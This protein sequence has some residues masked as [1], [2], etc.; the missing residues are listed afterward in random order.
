MPVR[1]FLNQVIWSGNS[2]KY[3][4]PSCGNTEMGEEGS[5]SLCLCALT[6]QAM[7]IDHTAEFL[8]WYY[9]QPLPAL[10]ID[11][12]SVALH[13]YSRSLLPDSN[14]WDIQPHR[15]N[16][17]QILHSPSLRYCSIPQTHY[18]SKSNKSPFSTYSSC[19]FC[20][21]WEPNTARV[22]HT[23]SN[24]SE[25]KLIKE[26]FCFGLRVWGLIWNLPFLSIYLYN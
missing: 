15:L 16:N 19:W 4:C 23:L 8:S 10:K 9:H 12:T 21:S 5:F 17:C 7:F 20:P 2:H 13:C 6:R 14:S 22:V 26:V 24:F 3:G 18:A 25:Y 1:D 11:C